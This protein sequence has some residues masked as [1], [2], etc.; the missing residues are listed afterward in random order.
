[1]DSAPTVLIVEDDRNVT[2]VAVEVLRDRGYAT[3]ALAETDVV[4]VLAAV[5][6]HRPVCVLLDGEGPRGYG[7][8]WETAAWLA[9]LDPAI[10]TIMFTADV[11]AAEAR[12]RP[13]LRSRAARFASVLTMPF[14]IH[15]L[16]RA[17]DQATSRPP[18]A[19]PV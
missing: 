7:A 18:L 3:V 10:P 8:S 11:R 9:R 17:V 19:I 5:Q 6:R 16:E 13:S 2:A 14:D 1:M 4:S 15:D 12:G